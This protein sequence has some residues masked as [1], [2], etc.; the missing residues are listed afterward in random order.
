MRSIGK[1]YINMVKKITREELLKGYNDLSDRV[2]ERL[3]SEIFDTWEMAWSQVE[4]I[5]DEEAVI[6][7]H[8]R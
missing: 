2:R 3:P 6:Y 8:R 7:S 1:K 5:I 4:N